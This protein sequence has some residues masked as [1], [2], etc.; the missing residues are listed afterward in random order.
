VYFWEICYIFTHFGIF[1][2]VYCFSHFGIL[3]REKSGNSALKA[4]ETRLSFRREIFSARNQKF[5]KVFR[6]KKLVDDELEK[7]V[8][9]KKFRA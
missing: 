6:L 9:K 3:Y 8:E 4:R 7:N 1:Y 2:I 5:F